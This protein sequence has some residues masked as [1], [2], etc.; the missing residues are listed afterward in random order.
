MI[1]LLELRVPLLDVLR[2]L[3]AQGIIELTCQFPLVKTFQN[4]FQFLFR[5]FGLRIKE[6]GVSFLYLYVI[7]FLDPV[8][9]GI[10]MLSLKVN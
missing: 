1:L 6:D 3:F 5:L 2:F 8:V 4:C 7:R 9:Q 10:P